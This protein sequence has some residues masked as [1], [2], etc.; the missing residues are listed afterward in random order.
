MRKSA[1]LLLAAIFMAMAGCGKKNPVSGPPPDSNPKGE[2]W[3]AQTS[4]TTESI[5]SVHFINESEGWVTVGNGTLLHTTN[6]GANWSTIRTGADPSGGLNSVRFIDKNIGWTGGVYSVIRTLNGGANWGGVEFAH[7]TSFRNS[8]FPVSSTQ[9][10]GVGSTRLANFAARAHWRYTFNSDGSFTIEN[11]N[12]VANETMAEVY[13]IDI[14]NGWSVGSNGRII[15]LTNASG[16]APVLTVQPSGTTQHLSDVRM[17]D[18]NIGWVVGNK[19]TILKTTNG[20]NAWTSQTSGTTIDLNAIAFV[21]F[22]TG[23]AVGDSGIIL[24][25][26]NGGASWA[27]QNSGTTNPLFDTHFGNANTGWAVGRFGTILK[28]VTGGMASAKV[29]RNAALNSPALNSNASPWPLA[30]ARRNTSAH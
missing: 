27:K 10:W 2:P 3:V 24:H 29:N 9:A 18:A 4:G 14:D 21:D 12:E 8:L 26:T 11:Y 25:T 5:T 7:H 16:R 1:L 6:G 17:V 15:R 20:G 30:E 23:T 22:N 28:T 19:G 13:F